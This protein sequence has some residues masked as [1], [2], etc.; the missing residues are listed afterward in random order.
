[1]E[2][3]L[4]LVIIAAA[5]GALILI[6]VYRLYSINRE[7]GQGEI[8]VRWISPEETRTIMYII[9]ALI[10]LIVAVYI[11]SEALLSALSALLI[12]FGGMLS[13]LTFINIVGKQ[14]MY[15][16]RTRKGLTWDEIEKLA[17]VQEGNVY[18]LEIISIRRKKK[19]EA[20]GFF[21]RIQRELETL[22]ELDKPDT[23]AEIKTVQD[24]SGE[25]KI[26]VEDRLSKEREYQ[27]K[28]EKKKI[29]ES[30][31][32]KREEIAPTDKKKDKTKKKEE[33]VE[34]SFHA[35]GLTEKH[36]FN[37]QQALMYY[38]PKG[39]EYKTAE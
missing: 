26:V 31:R 24:E 25:T 21:E 27:R 28:L 9:I 4:L 5:F 37:I 11:R 35:I 15:L 13:Q 3:S 20:S 17:F 32:R 16:G 36:Q 10:A 34:R 2:Y 8:V 6:Q 18:K 30:Y 22:E 39:I 38:F 33:E 14:G 7:W 29:E 12:G 19:S 23:Q 1:M